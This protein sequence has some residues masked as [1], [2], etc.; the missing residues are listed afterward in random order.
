MSLVSAWVV[1]AKHLAAGLLASTTV[2]VLVVK[3][4]WG[5]QPYATAAPVTQAAATFF[6]R[7]SF[8][9]VQLAF[10]ETPWLVAYRDDTACGNL[11]Q[12]ID[13]AISTAASYTPQAYDRVLVVTPCRSGSEGSPLTEHAIVGM[14]LEAKIVEHE[15]GHTFGM[16]H[17][18]ALQCTPRCGL[19]PYGNPID[20]MGTGGGDF[21]ALQKVQA[22]WPVNV[23][24]ATMPATYTLGPV[25]AASALPQALVL[26]RGRVDIWIEHRAAVGNDVYL[27]T[28]IWKRATAGVLVHEAPAGSAAIPFMQRRPDFLLGTP[29]AR[30]PFIA[31]GS[32]FVVPHVVEI[33]VLRHAGTAVTIRLTPLR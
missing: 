5:P 27:A 14:P 32:R 18:G 7:S 23:V 28:S 13:T 8:G 26:R 10:T 24:D 11:P 19:D 31:K 22:G 6:G 12:L 9:T 29:T 16:S 4:T 33:D 30:S 2:H 3:A 21:G 25:E 1:A 15:L 20:V 17:A